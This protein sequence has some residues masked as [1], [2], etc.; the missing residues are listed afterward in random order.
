MDYEPN[1]QRIVKER[2]TETKRNPCERQKPIQKEKNS[3]GKS[4][5]I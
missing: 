1:R 5:G 4:K 2:K 3:K